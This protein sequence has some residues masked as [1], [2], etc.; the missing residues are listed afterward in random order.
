MAFYSCLRFRFFQYLWAFSKSQISTHQATSTRFYEV[1]QVLTYWLPI[2]TVIS[3]R[4]VGTNGQSYTSHQRIKIVECFVHGWV[5]K[6]RVANDLIIQR[7]VHGNLDCIDHFTSFST[8]ERAAE[9]LICICI[10][11]TF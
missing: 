7:G 2:G 11:Y 8:E 9:Y 4:F 1:F 10:D 5:S 6:N 3:Q